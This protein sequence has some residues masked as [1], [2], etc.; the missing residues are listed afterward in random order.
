VRESLG[1]NRNLDASWSVNELGKTEK[2]TAKIPGTIHTDLLAARK[3]PDPYFGYNDSLVRWIGEKTWEYTC[4]FLPSEKIWKTHKK[5][6][7][8]EGLDTYA[9]VY[10]NGKLI[11][12]ADN[13][14]CTWRVD[15]SKLLKRN[16]NALR[17][18]FHPVSETENRLLQA[19][20]YRFPE[21]GRVFTRKAQ[22]HYGWDFSPRMLTC[23]IW[24]PVYLEGF[25]GTK[26]SDTHIETL[27]LCDDSAVVRISSDIDVQQSVLAQVMLDGDVLVAKKMNGSDLKKDRKFSLTFVVKN[28]KRWWCNGLGDPFLY[29][30]KLYVMSKNDTIRQTIKHGFRHLRIVTD[31]DKTGTGSS[32]YV[33]LNG[34]PVFMRGANWVPPDIFVHR[35]YETDDEKKKERHW[36][37]ANNKVVYLLWEAQQSHF[38]ML[39]VW[40]GGVYEDDRFYDACDSLG[41]LIWQDFMFAGSPYPGTLKFMTD[42]SGEVQDNVK[43][44]R[45]HACLAL[46]CGNNEIDEGW[47]NW[48][49]QRD[50]KYSKADSTE[51]WNNYQ[52]LFH[53]AIPKHLAKLDSGRFYWPSSPSGGWG[54]NASY[55]FGD[56]HYWGVWWGARDFSSYEKSVGR[57]VS[58]YGF[59]GIPALASLQEMAGQETQSLMDLSLR[60]HQK[61]ARGFATIRSFITNYYKEPQF[62]A[63]YIYLSQL[64]QADGYQAA[65]DAHRRAKPYCMGSLFWQW[66]DPWPG[67]GWSAMDW[68]G[69]KKLVAYRA[70]EAFQPFNITMHERNDSVIITVINDTRNAVAGKLIVYS[71]TNSGKRDTLQ[72]LL[73]EYS[74][75]KN[76]E[77]FRFA[78][79]ELSKTIDWTTRVLV[80]T[81]NHENSSLNRR[82]IFYGTDF[83]NFKLEKKAIG[84]ATQYVLAMGNSIVLEAQTL[85]R[86]IYLSMPDD[87]NAVFNTNGFDLL[88]GEKK[89][90]YVSAKP[91]GSSLEER[92]HIQTLNDVIWK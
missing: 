46:W 66:N 41:L 87:A 14:F 88:P 22:F 7:V 9:D 74:P 42:V 31:K 79:K 86:R 24:R 76:A 13:M 26:I 4:Q 18:V 2:F 39:R 57:F 32:F 30:F 85:T 69:R 38:N 28:P 82:V 92:I 90:I 25:S 35:A 49:W 50:L 62:F 23:G 61:N 10:L 44:L 77:V 33:E 16:N 21:G 68:Y 11:L 60:A 80:A 19:V 84:F 6:L 43:R 73:I 83:R 52:S 56:V 15:V 27:S 55:T 37:F 75:T 58:E 20:P 71:C 48:G 59:Q 5:E 70:A 63:D 8:F 1:S 64:V 12:R 54:R 51:V 91:S 89:T 29:A 36:G 72:N 34:I 47:H 81:F 45:N 3:I 40:G 53:Q 65:I 17:I 67:I 78:K